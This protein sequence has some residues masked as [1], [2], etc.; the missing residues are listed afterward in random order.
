MKPLTHF[1]LLNREGAVM[2]K[3]QKIILVLAVSLFLSVNVYSQNFNDALRLSEPGIISG[4]RSLAMGNA[5]VAL[6]NDFS[7]SL[8]NPAGLG[9]IKKSDLSLGMNYNSFDTV[10]IFLTG[11]HRRRT[12]LKNSVPSESYSRSLLFRAVL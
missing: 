4:A 2:K 7:S 3:L 8:F 1:N 12:M 11:T 5:Y 9:L 6:S 10:R